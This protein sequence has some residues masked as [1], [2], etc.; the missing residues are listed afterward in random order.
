MGL[1]QPWLDASKSYRPVVRTL[2][3]EVARQPAGCV[4]GSLVSD[5]MAASV[6]YFSSI[7]L[8][9]RDVGDCHLQL[10]QGDAQP[11]TMLLWEAP[12]RVNGMS[13]FI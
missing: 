10:L 3:A 9:R 13:T 7:A 1:W 4:D 5:S 6:D 8:R 11:G 2:A 12:A